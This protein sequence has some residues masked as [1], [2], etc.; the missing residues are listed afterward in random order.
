MTQYG[1][2]LNRRV[3]F[4]TNTNGTYYPTGKTMG[5]S[6]GRGDDATNVNANTD[7][8]STVSTDSIFDPTKNQQPKATYYDPAGGAVPATANMA[9]PRNCIIRSVEVITTGASLN[10]IQ[11]QSH[12]GAKNFTPAL[13]TVWAAANPP[14]RI[15]L[16]MPVGGGFRVVTATGTACSAIV[17]YDILES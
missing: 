3:M 17:V 4:I 11:I 14:R 15:V 8:A 16:D 2:D 13:D 9:S 1:A 7:T 5:I 10:T 6:S 12:T